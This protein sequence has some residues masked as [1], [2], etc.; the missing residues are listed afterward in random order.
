[1]FQ[2]DSAAYISML[3]I[4]LVYLVQYRRKPPSEVPLSSSADL[5]AWDGALADLL[6][7]DPGLAIKQS[8]SLVP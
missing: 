1:V 8:R 4:W 2:V 5:H 6:K 3:T 7:A